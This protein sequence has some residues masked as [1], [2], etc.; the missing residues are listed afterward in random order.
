MK[1]RLLHGKY[2]KLCKLSQED[3]PTFKRLL[4]GGIDGNILYITPI[5]NNKTL[6]CVDFVIEHHQIFYSESD[7]KLYLVFRP[8]WNES[9]NLRFFYYDVDYYYDQHDGQIVL[10]AYVHYSRRLNQDE[11]TYR[12][13]TIHKLSIPVIRAE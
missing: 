3:Y 13:Y 1:T 9:G 6:E 4:K 2:D 5:E 8:L 7:G 11:V 10:W 12:H